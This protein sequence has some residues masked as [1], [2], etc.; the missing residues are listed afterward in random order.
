MNDEGTLEH[1][2][3]LEIY[4]QSFNI[5]YENYSNKNSALKNLDIIIINNE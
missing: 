2:T 5:K 3:F 1:L 4:K